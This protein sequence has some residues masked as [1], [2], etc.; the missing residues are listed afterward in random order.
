LA[1]KFDEAAFQYCSRDAPAAAARRWMAPKF[2][3]VMKG[4]IL[5]VKVMKLP[6]QLANR[7]LNWPRLVKHQ[8]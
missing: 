7:V 8:R 2:K 3:L 1:A 4:A 5:L 6:Y